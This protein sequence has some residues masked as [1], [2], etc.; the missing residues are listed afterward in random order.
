MR[1]T[2]ENVLLAAQRAI[3]INFVMALSWGIGTFAVGVGA[4]LL[5][6][7]SS[8]SLS[9]TH[10]AIKAFAVSLVGGL[11]SIKG[12]IP[13]AA[14]VAAAELAANQYVNPRLADAIPFLIMLIVL[15]IRPWG[16]F[17]TEEEHERVGN[18]QVAIKRHPP[19]AYLKTSYAKELVI[20]AFDTPFRKKSLIAGILRPA[21]IPFV[22]SNYLIHIVNMAAIAAIGALALNLL[23]GNAGLLSLGQAGFM[24]SGA[25]T[26]AILGERFGMPAWVVLPTAGVV[27]ALLGFLAGLPSLRLKGMYLGLSTL[28]V[29]YLIVYALSEYQYYGGS[30]FGIT[31]K[32]DETRTVCSV[33]DKA[34][35]FVLCLSVLI[36][37]L[38][39]K[40]LLRSR[41][42]RAWIAL[43]D[44]DVAAEIIGINIG[45]YKI[46]A[47]VVSSSI[48]AMSGSLYAYYT[49]V[50]TIEEYSFRA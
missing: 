25:F 40:N 46:L 8:V 4:V 15:I 1:A 29:H 6:A 22:S 35:Y 20:E 19:V 45:L 39:I 37:A 50:A 34:W 43:H 26:T 11:D 27:G 5:G 10:M 17:G 14:I 42:G 21:F 18:D 41:P 12:I 33:S 28:A 31:I 23:C 30:G 7:F 32:I 38:F 9:M 2:A 24:A 13:A 47:F 3:N 44:R 16:L 48:T 36:V 49:R